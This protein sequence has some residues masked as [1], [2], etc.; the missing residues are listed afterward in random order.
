MNGATPRNF[1][2]NLNTNDN[3]IYN[4]TA[5]D[6]NNIRRFRERT[7][8]FKESFFPSCVNKW[9]KLNNFSRKAESIKHLRYILKEFF[10]GKLK[11]FKNL[12]QHLI[13]YY[14]IQKNFCLKIHFYVLKYVSA[15]FIFVVLHLKIHPAIHLNTSKALTSLY[16]KQKLIK[17]LLAF[18]TLM[19]S[20]VKKD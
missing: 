18:V 10:K 1:T 9:Y 3:S 11:N 4:T 7:E 17:S 20:R 14:I 2:N 13:K 8:H 15:N 5:L 12:T 6:Q 16:Q 19:L